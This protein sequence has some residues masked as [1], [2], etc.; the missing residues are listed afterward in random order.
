VPYIEQGGIIMNS[1][2]IPFLAEAILMLA[3][4][5]FG[6]LLDRAGK[7]YGKVKLVVHLFLFA[8]LTTGFGFILYGL[9]AINIMKVISIPVALMGLTILTQL[10]VGIPM[11]A[12]KKRGKVLTKIHLVSAIL[13]LLSD[14]CAFIIA[15]IPSL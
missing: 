7:P 5:T 14:I 13:M 15:G 10:V 8:W 12:S 3:A 9:S 2:Q 11:I 4:G 1:T 6:I